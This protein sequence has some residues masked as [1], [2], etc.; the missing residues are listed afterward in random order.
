MP[1]TFEVHITPTAEADIAEIWDYIAQDS[2]EQ[3]TAFV[4]ALEEQ[5]ASLE[6]H[7]ERCPR[8]PENEVLGTPYRHLTHGSY[9]TVFRVAGPKVVILRVVHGARLLDTALFRS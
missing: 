9:R 1:A 5:I 6:R 7:P 8:I 3:A 2:P 4:L